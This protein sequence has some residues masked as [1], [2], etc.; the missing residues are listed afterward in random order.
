MKE[1]GGGASFCARN[2]ALLFSLGATEGAFT[3]ATA[4]DSRLLC[5]GTPS[6]ELPFPFVL[7]LGRTRAGSAGLPCLNDAARVIRGANSGGA[8]EATW[9]VEERLCPGTSMKVRASSAFVGA[10]RGPDGN[11]RVG[12]TGWPA[13]RAAARVVRGWME[14]ARFVAGTGRALNGVFPVAVVASLAVLPRKLPAVEELDPDPCCEIECVGTE[15][16][17]D[18]ILS[19]SVQLSGACSSSRLRPSKT[20]RPNSRSTS[21]Y[22]SCSSIGSSAGGK[23][24]L[25]AKRHAICSSAVAAFGEPTNAFSASEV[26]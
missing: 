8:V 7:K 5:P 24:G 26:P 14:G 12:A 3:L 10:I 25:D 13:R 18:W 21:S 19:F 1:D 15:D 17:G 23:G 9:I 22:S 2:A 20:N 4:I 11:V 6:N 16:D